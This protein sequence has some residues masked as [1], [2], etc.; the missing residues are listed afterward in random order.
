MRSLRRYVL[1]LGVAVA[2][3]AFMTLPRPTAAQSTGPFSIQVTPSPLVTTLKPGE[4]TNLELKVRN[5]GATTEELKIAPRTFKVSGDSQDLQISDDQ[6]PEIAKWFKFSPQTFTVSSGQTTTI[7]ITIAVPKEAGFSYAFAMVISRA[8]ATP[9]QLGGQSIK[10]SVAVFALLN[11]DRP[12]AVRSLEISKFTSSK[13]SYEYLPAEFEIEFKN[14]GNTI[15]QPAGTLF[16]Q[17]GSDDKKPIDTLEVND[18]GSYILPG[19]T[20]TLK[21][22]WDNGFLVYQ[23]KTDDV[24]NTTQELVW[25]W[26]KFGDMRFGQYT[27]KLVAIYNDGYRDV[28]LT[29]EATF[30]VFPWMI[31]LGVLV[32]LALLVF[33]VWSLIA[34][35][36]G[37]GKRIK[38]L[39]KKLHL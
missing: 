4:T 23:P 27:A 31:A 18:A 30:W 36:I 14:T 32:V 21:M 26:N 34:K 7:K 38:Q 9:Q 1:T 33:G 8:N 20:R 35:I 5:A 6:E 22:T 19:T 17:R 15:V 16:I 10:A 11:V 24:G 13:K 37:L 12:G 39:K 3:V 29:A 28:P 2:A 25:N